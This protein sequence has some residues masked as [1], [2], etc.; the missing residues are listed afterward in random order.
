MQ[1]AG[2]LPCTRCPL[3]ARSG[4][5]AADEEAATM[6]AEGEKLQGAYEAKL[7]ELCDLEKK[8]AYLQAR[9]A[10]RLRSTAR[11]FIV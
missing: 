7:E 9:S 4:K 1:R 10:P 2:G 5:A 11:S 3:A 8:L 6:C